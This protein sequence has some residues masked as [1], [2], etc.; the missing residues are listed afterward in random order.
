MG[1][2]CFCQLAYGPIV[3]DLRLSEVKRFGENG[4]FGVKIS[5]LSDSLRVGPAKVHSLQKVCGFQPCFPV[6][7]GSFYFNVPGGTV[8]VA[9]GLELGVRMPPPVDSPHNPKN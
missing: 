8:R 1:K 6:K 5:S 7:R 9:P 4:C 3:F 2:P